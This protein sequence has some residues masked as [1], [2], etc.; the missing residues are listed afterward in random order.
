MGGGAVDANVGIDRALISL[1]GFRIGYSDSY[2]TTHHGYGLPVEKY[3][4][5]YGYDQA[6][7]L[8]YT[9]AANGFLGNCWYS[10]FSC[11]S[12]ETR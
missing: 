6:I 2:T 3:D 5:P 9:Y 8:D 4:G 1:G 12:Y 7:F 11:F 10:V